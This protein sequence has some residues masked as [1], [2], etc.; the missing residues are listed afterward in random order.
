MNGFNYHDIRTA[1][2]AHPAATPE[3]TRRPS[4]QHVKPPWSVIVSV[5]L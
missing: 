4:L 2:L 1:A 5:D 3:E